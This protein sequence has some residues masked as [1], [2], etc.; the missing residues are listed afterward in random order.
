MVNIR[1]QKSKTHTPATKQ[2]VCAEVA[3]LCTVGQWR[4]SRT[5]F[6]N[7]LCLPSLSTTTMLQPSHLSSCSICV[8][9]KT[10]MYK[11]GMIVPESG[12]YQVIHDRYHSAV[13]EV[14]AIRGEVFPPCRHCGSGMGYKLVRAAKHLSEA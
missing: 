11:P 12:L 2:S 1:T 4:R 14:T 10:R 13:H 7:R 8:K 5:S 3:L 6:Q 9:R